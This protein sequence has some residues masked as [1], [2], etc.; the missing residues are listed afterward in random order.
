MNI[1]INKNKKK[2][3]KKTYMDEYMKSITNNCD[4]FDINKNNFKN[5]DRD[6]L[7]G[8]EEFIP[9]INN[10][11]N[12][13]KH[14]YTLKH[15]K[16]IAK[17]YKQKVGGTIKELRSRIYTYLYLSYNALKIQK[18]FRGK[19]QRI[20]NNCHGPAFKN[21]KLCV[22]DTDFV[23][24]DE[25]TKIKFNN[26]FSYRDEDKFIY[27]FDIVSL[28]TLFTNRI[29]NND[30]I[31]NPYN[32]NKIPDNVLFNLKKII[33]ISKILKMDIDYEIEDEVIE[34]SPEQTLKHRTL[35]LFQNID[36]LGNYS[37]P[38]W[39][40][41]LNINNLLKLMSELND[42]WTY[43]AQLTD[44]LKRKIC[45]PYGDPFANFNFAYINGNN[46]I[47]NIKKYV[48][49]ILEKFVNNGIDNDSK[50]LGSYYVLGSLTLVNENAAFAIP[51]L[52]QSMIYF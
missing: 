13:I 52:F 20:Y 4:K 17:F 29:N 35:S 44:E 22:N 25:L 23:T 21:I 9:C 46:D 2:N 47:N 50:I 28:Y 45:P 43:R 6:E 51:W 27:G 36:A 14:K 5:V 11:D 49:T 24:L 39:F 38:D 10:Y 41:S 32:R 33:R 30:K 18:V 48:L 12:I 42:I 3:D 31:N 16:F 7:D 34:M 26:F 15:L 8:L 19:L 1:T 37:D 40:N